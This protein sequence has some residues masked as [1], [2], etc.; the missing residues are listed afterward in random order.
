VTLRRP[1][2]SGAGLAGT[3]RRGLGATLLV[4]GIIALAINLRAA[5]TSLPPLFPEMSAT[6]HLSSA[7]LAALASVPVLCFGLFSPVAAPLSLRFGEERVLG[8]AAVLLA[9]GLLLRSAAPLVLLFPGTVVASAA[10]AMMNVLLPSLVKR[11]RPD[12]A[13]LL[14]GL[15]LMCL[16]GGAIAGSLVAVP[17]FTAAGGGNGAI[18]LT[19]G[20]WALPALV[21]A[22][23]WL[24][25]LRYRSLPPASARGGTALPPDTGMPPDAGLPPGGGQRPAAVAP[26]AAVLPGPAGHHGVLSM[27]R[28]A[29]AWQVTAFMGLQSLLYYAT[30][31]WFPTM[32]R[33]RGIS[34]V[35]AGDL[36]ALMNLGNAVTAML[37]PV[38]A[39]RARDQR[40]LVAVSTVTT[41]AGLAGAAFGPLGTAVGW[42]LLLGLGQGATLG[43]GIFLTMARAPDPA[44]AASLSGFAQGGGYLL[45]A[46]GPLFVGLLHSA[47]R[48]WAIPVGALLGIGVLQLSIGLLAGRALTVPQSHGPPRSLTPESG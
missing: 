17:V 9:A 23:A 3:G 24:P 29:L 32:F 36:L 39:H 34:A 2:L 30:L 19:L 33:D 44:T 8:S 41:A 27:A 13:G 15:Y 40:V 20:L 7:S 11:R 4:A 48:G 35:H 31:S 46:T 45:S 6:L 21:A 26:P 28:Y 47:T 37:L 12:Q 18:R 42:V 22:V 5:I 10:I 14:I 1:D 16:S 25:Q 38:L 43:L